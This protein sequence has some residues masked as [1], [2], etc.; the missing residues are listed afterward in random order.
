MDMK[1]YRQALARSENARQTAKAYLGGAGTALGVANA[2][3]ASKHQ[4]LLYCAPERLI[5]NVDNLENRLLKTG[6]SKCQTALQL[7]NSK[8]CRSPLFC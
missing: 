7:M 5:L 1:M 8:N 6:S 2:E 3:L 4:S